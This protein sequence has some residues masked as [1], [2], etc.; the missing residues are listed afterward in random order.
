MH[1]GFERRKTAALVHVVLT[2][3]TVSFFKSIAVTGHQRNIK[4]IGCV[5]KYVSTNLRLRNLQIYILA[6]LFY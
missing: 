5:A 1:E 4:I 3:D 2:Y 6:L